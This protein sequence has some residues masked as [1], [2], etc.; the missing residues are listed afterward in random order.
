M[1]KRALP[2]SSVGTKPYI[3]Y[4]PSVRAEQRAT[5]NVNTNAGNAGEEEHGLG[6]EARGNVSARGFHTRRR[7]VIFNVRVMD[8]DAPSY[9]NKTSAKVIETAEKEKCTKYEEV[10]SE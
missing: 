6:D 4:G 9:R 2:D 8:T 5:P 10:C 7:V 1:C 3:F